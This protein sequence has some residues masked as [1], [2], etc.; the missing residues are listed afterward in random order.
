MPPPAAAAAMSLPHLASTA[1]AAAVAPSLSSTVM[2]SALHAVRP[3]RHSLN[4]RRPAVA[5]PVASAAAAASLVAARQSH[6]AVVLDDFCHVLPTVLAPGARADHVAAALA[7][8]AQCARDL[9]HAAVILAEDP[10]VVAALPANADD[11]LVALRAARAR[12]DAATRALHAAWSPM[13]GRVIV[14]RSAMQRV[15]TLLDAFIA[16]HLGARLA[17]ADALHVGS[18][19]ETHDVDPHAVTVAAIHD[20]RA[21]AQFSF[22]TAPEVVLKNTSVQAHSPLAC[23]A[24]LRAMLR[25]PLRAAMHAAAISGP[26]QHPVKVKIVDGREDLAFHISDRGPGL[27]QR[28]LADVFHYGLVTA[29]L[30]HA[31]MPALGYSPVISTR[32][33]VPTPTTPW[34]P[35]GR[36]RRSLFKIPDVASSSSSPS[37][38]PLFTAATSILQALGISGFGPRT[39]TTANRRAPRV[40]AP[41]VE[42]FADPM[43]ATT[44]NAAE[45]EPVMTMAD[46]LGAAPPSALGHVLH[47]HALD[48]SLARRHARYFGGDLDV[49]SMENHGTDQY[50]HLT[51][52]VAGVTEA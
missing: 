10:S 17:L 11:V 45:R 6:A 50:L 43:A 24:S 31:K 15:G 21:W 23:E 32:D 28:Q 29:P 19:L 20:A 37:P 9:T 39:S 41:V 4:A 13:V 47:E 18:G 49:V 36:R 12:H 22:G 26:P 8:L 7:P 46:I 35:A 42:T 1:A 25:G 48:L 14:D 52:D 27:T 38:S 51:K 40:A 2:A 30:A 33:P 34:V 3:L 44:A 16:S 5:D